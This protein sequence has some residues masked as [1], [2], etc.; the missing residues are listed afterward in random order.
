MPLPSYRVMEVEFPQYEEL[1]TNF[2]VSDVENKPEAPWIKRGRF[3]VI[4]TNEIQ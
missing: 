2:K 1:L 4:F 3:G